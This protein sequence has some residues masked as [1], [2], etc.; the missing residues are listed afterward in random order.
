VCTAE[1]VQYDFVCFWNEIQ[2]IG[3][4]GG[5][6]RSV[7]CCYM[8]CHV[9]VGL[10]TCDCTVASAQVSHRNLEQEKVFESRVQAH[11]LMLQGPEPH[12]VHDAAVQL[13]SSDTL[14]GQST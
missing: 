10:Q 11:G 9:V 3:V 4:F 5:G 8:T 6:W 13:E 7:I 14:T 1:A 12:A 2:L